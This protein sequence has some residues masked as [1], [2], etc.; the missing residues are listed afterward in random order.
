MVGACLRFVLNGEAAQAA[1]LNGGTPTA[2]ATALPVSAM[3]KFGR[4]LKTIDR[5]EDGFSFPG[6]SDGQDRK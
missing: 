1:R 6:R 4:A 5:F 3:W 2:I